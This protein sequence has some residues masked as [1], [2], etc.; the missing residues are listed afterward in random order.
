M[1]AGRSGG[2]A[3]QKEELGWQAAVVQWD[4]AEVLRSW[5]LHRLCPRQAAWSLPPCLGSV[6]PSSVSSRGRAEGSEA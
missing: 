2:L 1:P 6:S 4:G 5:V 3:R